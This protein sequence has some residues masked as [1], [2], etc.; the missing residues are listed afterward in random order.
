MVTGGWRAFSRASS[1]RRWQ[2]AGPYLLEGSGG[3]HVGQP[4]DD[5]LDIWED[6]EQSIQGASQAWREGGGRGRWGRAS[7]AM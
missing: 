4:A 6:V 5:W 2:Q 3:Q 7:V 1:T